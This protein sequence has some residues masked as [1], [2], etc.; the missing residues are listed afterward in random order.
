[1]ALSTKLGLAAA[2][3]TAIGVGSAH[4]ALT[5][6]SSVGGAP[7]GV[8]KWNMDDGVAPAGLAVTLTPDAAF[9]TGS[10]SG[11][12]A[13][14]N[15]SGG[16]GLGFGAG[17]GNQPDGPNTTQYLTTG[18]TGAMPSA[19]V[20]IAFADAQMYVGLLWGSVDDY[21]TLSFYSGATL[22][23]SITGVE[24]LASPTGSQGPDGT[25]YV[26]INSSVAF[27]RIVFT[28]SQYAFEFD[29]LAWNDKPIP[30]PE[31]A[32]LALLG[33]GLL[34]LGVASRRRRG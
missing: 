8:N 34:G 15:L 20:E 1:M 10:V 24:V 6:V 32:S 21:N 18:S 17:G 13:A 14:P 25:V 19:S 26:N 30:T 11:V 3:V 5:I 16:N 31:P 29:N 4:A 27:D 28:S 23:E 7:T 22:I 2:L 9:V 12:Y 33:M